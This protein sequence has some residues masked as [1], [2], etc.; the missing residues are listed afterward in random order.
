MHDP[1]AIGMHDTELVERLMA[2]LRATMGPLGDPDEVRVTRWE[3][4]L[5]QYPPGHLDTVA[6]IER[7]LARHAP[8]LVVTGAALRGL[9]IPA[10]IRQG[11]DAATQVRSRLSGAP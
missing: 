5:P 10:C 3:R 7:D 8:G 6:A 4:G 11:R 2:D 9:G 1:R